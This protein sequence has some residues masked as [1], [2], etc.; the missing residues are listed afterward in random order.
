[1]QR[2]TLI[3]IGL[4]GAL[5]S[6]TTS[7]PAF[8]VAAI[9]KNTVE[10]PQRQGTE[11]GPPPPPPPVLRPSPGGLTIENATLKYCLVWA[12]GVRNSQVS[13]PSWINEAHYDIYAKAGAPSEIGQL[14][15]MLQTLLTVRFRLG[16]QRDTKERPVLGIVTARS[17]SKLVPS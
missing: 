15:E 4:G 2:R 17:G 16:L 14:K 11:D 1:M 12:Y 9:R 6:Q 3:V 10:A 13:G 5:R 8:E 7:P